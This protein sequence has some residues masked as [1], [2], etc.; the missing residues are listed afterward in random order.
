VPDLV[1]HAARMAPRAPLETLRH[2]IV[3]IPD[4]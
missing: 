3:E 2:V 1:F 4:D